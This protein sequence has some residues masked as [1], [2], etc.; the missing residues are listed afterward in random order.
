MAGHRPPALLRF[1]WRP[2]NRFRLL[3]DGPAFFPAMLE[4]I[5]GARRCVY[6]EM[7]LV[8]SGAV[9][10][11]FVEALV[12][13]RA[14][15]AEV[16]VLLD[17]FGSRGLAA[18]DRRRLEAAGVRLAFYNPLRSREV[19]RYLLRD[20]RKILVV[21]GE[22]AFVGGMGLT[23]DFDPPDGRL[24]WRETVVEAAGPVA[25]DWAA[26]FAHTWERVT[27]EPLDPPCPC[28]SRA[29]RQ[30][31]RV[32]GSWGL[33]DPV[34]RRSVLRRIRAARE[35]VWLATAYFVPTRRLRRALA[36]A[37]ARGVDVRLLLPGPRTDHPAVRHAGRRHYHALLQRGVRI[38]EYQ[39]RFL[40]AKMLLCDGWASV[41]SANLDRWTVRWN[42]EANQEVEDPA[43]AAELRAQFLRD[44]AEAA[45]CL[46][47]QWPRR[48][49]PA[50]ALE[51]FWA[52]T[53]RWVLR[54]VGDPPPWR[55]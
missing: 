55:R 3:A 14:R 37:A 42:L 40:H 43:F 45:E 31:G 36:R 28:G 29:G 7:Y 27:G 12:A 49:W 33:W 23:D 44:F 52:W 51:A 54:L 17:H 5:G 19:R 22:R 53:A 35:R 13:A 8:A 41:G 30:R 34:L 25:G 26:L 32:M 16:R 10:G 46:P 21:D 18:Q 9:L 6:L 4:A 38:F 11:R 48:P 39:P 47:G 2:G 1:P 15:G 50:R 24:P 20:H